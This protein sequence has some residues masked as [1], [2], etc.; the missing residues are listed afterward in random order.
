MLNAAV[1]PISY[2]LSDFQWWKL[3]L[4]VLLYSNTIWVPLQASAYA[5]FPALAG[6]EKRPQFMDTEAKEPLFTNFTKNFA[7]TLDYI[8]YTGTLFVCL[9]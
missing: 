7:G 6:D 1:C 3:P 9:I 2:F 4:L 8:F 5:S